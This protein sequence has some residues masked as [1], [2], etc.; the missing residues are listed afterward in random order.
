MRRYDLKEALFGLLEDV[1]SEEQ[2]TRI[3]RRRLGRELI[4]WMI[5]SFGLRK[6]FLPWAIVSWDKASSKHSIC[7]VT[8][9]QL[10]NMKRVWDAKV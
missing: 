10:N 5:Q 1:S 4:R 9:T 6:E 7:T 2:K 8:G 3:V